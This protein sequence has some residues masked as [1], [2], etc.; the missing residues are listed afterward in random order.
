MEHKLSHEWASAASQVNYPGL[1]A[2]GNSQLC[3]HTN[4]LI[5]LISRLWW[6]NKSTILVSNKEPSDG[7]GRL[8]GKGDNKTSDQL[9]Q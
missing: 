3:D 7:L 2:M 4:R 1:D 6:L 8:E 9:G 5:T